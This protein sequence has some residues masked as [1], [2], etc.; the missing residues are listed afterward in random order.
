MSNQEEQNEIRVTVEEAEKAVGIYQ[1]LVRLKNNEDFKLIIETMY[2]KEQAL[3][4]ISLLAHEGM[5]DKRE[6]IHEDLLSKSNLS[7]FMLIIESQG[8]RYEDDLIAY[9]QMQHEDMVE[10]AEAVNG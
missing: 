5:V 10:E 3:D 8:K 7:M 2:L 1:A 6:R 4:Q 9:K